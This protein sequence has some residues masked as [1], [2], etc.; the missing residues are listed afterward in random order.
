MEKRS[1]ENKS[2]E[3]IK[4]AITGP[5]STGKSMLAEQLANHFHTVFVPEFARE[6]INKLDR[7]YNYDDILKIAKGQLE[8]EVKLYSASNKIIFCDTELIVTKIWSD[9]AFKKCDSWITENIKNH[10]YDLYLLMDIDLPWEYDPQRE[11]PHMREYFL[12]LY[13]HELS[14]RH[15]PF[16]IISGQH[17]VRLQ[18]AVQEVMKLF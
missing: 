10:K 15:L 13:Q 18:N 3:L 17:E 6:Y 7:S 2:N 4:V 14:L 9:N 16:K 1:K 12:N 11:H 5:E 8:K